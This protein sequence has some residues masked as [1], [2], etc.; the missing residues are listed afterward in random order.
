MTSRQ[1]VTVHSQPYP[2]DPRSYQTSHAASRQMLKQDQGSGAHY[3]VQL[4]KKYS[5][6]VCSGSRK[7][8]FRCY[9]KLTKKIDT[10]PIYHRTIN[11]Q[12]LYLNKL[13][14]ISRIIPY[15]WTVAGDGGQQYKQ[16]N[17]RLC[18]LV[19]NYSKLH[20]SRLNFFRLTY[21]VIMIGLSHN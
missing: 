3:V 7:F 13:L 10:C 4:K 2:T 17:H 5:P 6:I 21:I 8:F 1:G 16:C 19:Q 11:N 12:E 9:L 20:N 15:T 14:D 18:A